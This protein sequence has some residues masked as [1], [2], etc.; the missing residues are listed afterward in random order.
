MYVCSFG[1]WCPSCTNFC[2]NVHIRSGVF[3]LQSTKIVNAFSRVSLVRNFLTPTELWAPQRLR[4]MLPLTCTG[5]KP[6]FFLGQSYY[7]R[8]QKRHRKSLPE[9]LLLRKEFHVF[10]RPY[11]CWQVIELHRQAA[12]QS[13]FE[14]MMVQPTVLWLSMFGIFK[15][16]RRSMKSFLVVQLE[17][18]NSWLLR[19]NENES[20]ISSG[21]VRWKFHW[22]L[23]AVEL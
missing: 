8:Q 1:K 12:E 5:V 21:A 10:I 22:S 3:S 16:L 4:Q 6:D 23:S 17:L 11:C 13:C 20:K 14:S 7:S 19:R 9:R 15:L 18:W 2:D